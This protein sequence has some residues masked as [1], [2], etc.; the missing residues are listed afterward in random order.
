VALDSS[1]HT[2]GRKGLAPLTSIYNSQVHAPHPIDLFVKS[3]RSYLEPTE[4]IGIRI[5]ALLLRIEDE[6]A[7]RNN[8]IGFRGGYAAGAEAGTIVCEVACVLAMVRREGK[9]AARAVA[10]RQFE[11]R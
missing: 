11:E 6:V 10:E 9:E 1:L 3:R 5:G 7:D 2:L 4:G 8:I